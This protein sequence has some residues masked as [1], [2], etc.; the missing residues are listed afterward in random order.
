MVVN[1]DDIPWATALL[2]VWMASLYLLDPTLNGGVEYFF[3]SPW[4]HSGWPHYWNNMA[5][6]LPL[7]LYTEWRTDSVALVVFAALIPYLALH[8]PVVWGLGGLSQGA[9][10]LTKALTS[11]V[12]MTLLIGFNNRLKRIIDHDFGW[13]EA[14]VAVVMLLAIAFLSVDAW[15]TV[16]RFFYLAPR[17]EGM[18]VASH[19]FGLIIGLFWFS[20]RTWQHGLGKA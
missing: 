6:F 1:R 2:T 16:Q 18:S 9:S 17:P 19:F 12:V 11:Y 15:V 20:F 14:A 5:F 10:G 7:G 8:L 4:M 3:L 13:R